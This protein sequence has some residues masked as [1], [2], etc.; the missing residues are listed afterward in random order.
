MPYD[1]MVRTRKRAPVAHM[2]SYRDSEGKQSYHETEELN[3]AIAYVERLRNDE[4]VDHARIFKMDELSDVVSGLYPNVVRVKIRPNPAQHPQHVPQLRPLPRFPAVRR[5]ISLVVAD[6]VRYAA[7]ESLIRKLNL[8]DLEDV[9]YVTTYR[10][11]PLE[12]GTKS[13]TTT[14]IFRSPTATLTS[15]SV[16]TSVQRVVTEAQK[17][18]NATLRT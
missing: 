4:A 2:V 3:D 16:E 15:E 6:D 7:L 14:L 9:E 12:K 11:K 1:V 13:L 17:N 10:G 5:D 18:L 8:P